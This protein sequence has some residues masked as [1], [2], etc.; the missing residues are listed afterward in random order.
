MAIEYDDDFLD[1]A[2][3]T[4]GITRHDAELLYDDMA[5]ELDSSYLELD[6]LYNYGDMASDL[7]EE[8]DGKFWTIA[9]RTEA[10]GTLE[11]CEVL[12]AE[13][14]RMESSGAVMWENRRT[15]PIQIEF[16]ADDRASDDVRTFLCTWNDGEIIEVHNPK[17]L[18][19]AYKDTNL[20]EEA[21]WFNVH[22]TGWRSETLPVKALLDS[23]EVG[24][25]FK[26][27]NCQIQRIK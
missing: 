27:D 7:V 10:Y 21:E 24:D 6:D 13:F 20:F 3:D 15:V 22:G 5:A 8:K 16:D 9:E 26:C 11:E 4:F 2:Q 1:V 18:H 17:S 12:L 19:E 14:I 25:A 23:V